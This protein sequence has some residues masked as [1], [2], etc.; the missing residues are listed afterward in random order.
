MKM[1]LAICKNL[2]SHCTLTHGF[3][4]SELSLLEVSKKFTKAN[5]FKRQMLRYK[6]NPIDPVFS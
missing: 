2:R 4:S 6:L 1:F 3:V 5:D